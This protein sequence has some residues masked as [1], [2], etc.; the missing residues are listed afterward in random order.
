MLATRAH[1][2]I[3]EI[4]A[5]AARAVPGVVAVLVAE[6]LPIRSDRSD[7]MA[8]PLA[9]GE[10]L[11]AGEPVAVVVATSPAAAADGA[12]LVRVRLEPLPVVLDPEAAMRP[13]APDARTDLGT[14]GGASMDAQTHAAVGGEGDASIEAE[15]LSSNVAARTRYRRGDTQAD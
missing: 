11:F 4:D 12:E 5:T 15:D 14:G 3:V 1:A 13:E 6:D 9:R 2:R 10:V 7:R 8:R